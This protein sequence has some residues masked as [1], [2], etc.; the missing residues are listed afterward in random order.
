MSAEF[1]RPADGLKCQ[2]CG[3]ELRAVYRTKQTAGFVMRERV[4]PHCQTLHT[5]SERIITAR[6]RFEK[7][8][9]SDPCE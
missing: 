9:F 1:R 2:G 8:R 3:A 7:R 4:C 6:P 5:T